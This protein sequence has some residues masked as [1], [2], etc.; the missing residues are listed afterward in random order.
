MRELVECKANSKEN[1]RNGFK[2]VQERMSGTSLAIQ[3]LKICASN[4]GYVGSIPA[5]TKIPYAVQC[6]QKRKE[7]QRM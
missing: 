2:G 6:G 5:G 3:W 7:K 1:Q 4:A